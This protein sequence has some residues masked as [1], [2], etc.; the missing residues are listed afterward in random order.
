MVA[1]VHRD[2][3]RLSW[4]SWPWLRA[5]LCLPPSLPC[6]AG[7]GAAGGYV[8][9][10]GRAAGGGGWPCGCP[11][12]CVSRRVARASHHMEA[13]RSRH[14]AAAVEQ[15]AAIHA[16]AGAGPVRGGPGGGRELRERRH[17]RSGACTHLGGQSAC[18][19]GAAG[20]STSCTAGAR[21]VG[22]ASGG[23][24]QRRGALPGSVRSAAKLGCTRAA[25]RPEPCD[26]AGAGRQPIS[27]QWLG[28]GG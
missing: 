9:G 17:L 23:G 24:G 8:G 22:K 12:R 19:E 27:T 4:R 5:A 14:R 16:S 13:L 1:R 28:C 3:L 6:R 26:R 20:R 21:A 2:F 7:G 11:S 10:A 15:R 18:V 25:A